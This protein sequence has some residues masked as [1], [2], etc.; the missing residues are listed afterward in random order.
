MNN[1][2]LKIMNNCN[3]K[4]RCILLCTVI[5]IFPIISV[6]SVCSEGLSQGKM[7]RKKMFTAPV[8]VSRI[9]QLEVPQPVKMVGT[10]VPFRESIVASEID[11]LVVEFPVKRGDYIKKGQVLAKLKTTTLKIQLKGAEAVL[12]VKRAAIGEA[13]AGEHLALIE[14]ERAKELYKSETISHQEYDKFETKYEQAIEIHKKE[15]AGLAAQEAEVEGIKDSIGKCTIT[16]PFD[17]RITEEYTEVGQWL[18]KGDRVVS[19]LQLDYVKVKIP[20]PEK[21]IQNLKIGDECEVNFQALGGITKVGHVVHIV[22]QADERA[23]TFPVYV[24]ID[25]SDEKLKSGMFAE[26]TFEIGPLLSAIMILKDG[27][28]RRAGG[29]LI[30]LAVEGKAVVAPVQTGIAYKNLIQIIGDVK[31]GLDVIV[32]GNERLLNAQ[33]VQVTGRMDPDILLDNI[34][35]PSLTQMD[36]QEIKREERR[37]TREEGE[38][39]MDKRRGMKEEG[40]GMKDEKDK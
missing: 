34:E 25:N 16:A 15:Q 23:R 13:E 39:G 11:G 20:V 3:N 18:D 10:V 22:P 14:F 1:M 9:V 8:V 26:A 38:W 24:K 32:R 40:R 17:G 12:E 4:L 30:F 7:F 35:S 31:P 6:F 33:N 5:L 27:I 29:K 36:S 37:G 2:R 28:V 21:Y 19:M